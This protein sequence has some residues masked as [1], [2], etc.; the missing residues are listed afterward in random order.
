MLP[1][2]DLFSVSENLPIVC[3]VDPKKIRVSEEKWEDVA[4]QIAVC[5]KLEEGL[6]DT[7]SFQCGLLQAVP[8]ESLTDSEHH[9]LERLI[10][11][12]D[13]PPSFNK[14]HVATTRDIAQKMKE[15]VAEGKKLLNDEMGQF[16]CC[17]F[18]CFRIKV[19][20]VKME[21]KKGNLYRPASK[22]NGG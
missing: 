19:K 17:I 4:R 20:A 6:E 16:C 1:H 9:Q 7:L 12:G 11:A 14:M 22:L 8:P 10:R 3:P 18:V 2:E 13:V 5:E 21:S 15:L